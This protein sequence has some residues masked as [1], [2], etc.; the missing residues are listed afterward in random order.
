MSALAGLWRFDGKP[1]A[2]EG[3]ARMLA[4]QSIYGPHDGRQWS[5]GSLALGRRLYRTLPEDSFDLQP[6]HGANDRFVLVADVRLDNREELCAALGIA[7]PRARQLCDADVLLA[8]LERWSE[9]ALERLTGDF[10]FALW[11]SRERSLLL[12]RDFVGQRPLFYHRGRDFFAFASTTRGLHGL[13]DVPRKPDEQAVAEFVA[14]IPHHGPRSFYE[15]IARVE[16]GHFVSVTREGIKSQ[17]YWNPP[18]PDPA[19]R[20]AGDHVEGLRHHLDEATKARLRG[21]GGTVA[22]HLSAGLDSAAVTATAARSLAASGGKVVAFTAVPR[23]GYEGSC[24]PGRIADEGPLAAATAALYPN[25]EHVLIRS[26][27]VS[28]VAELDRYFH[29]F[30]QPMIN[31]VNLAWLSSINAAARDRKLSIL[32]TG[33]MGNLSLSYAGKEFLPELLARGRPLDWLRES[34]HLVAAGRMRWRGA[35][36]TS[37]GPFLPRWLWQRLPRDAPGL[38]DYSALRPD[39]RRDFGLDRIAAERGMDPSLRP[40]RSAFDTRLHALAGADP[41]NY[42]K[43]WL[44]GWGIDPR[45]PTADRRLVEFCLLAP[46]KA[47]VAGGETRLMARRALGD[48]LPRTVIEAQTRGF[49]AADWHVGLSTA[50]EQVAADLDNLRRCEPVARIIDLDRLRALIDHWPEG[51]WHHGR[52]MR[53]YRSALLRGIASG[54]FLRKASGSNA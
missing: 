26:A 41:G 19:A 7:P 11:D 4:A 30:D 32:L 44:A 13:P 52:I 6:V 31:P 20:L 53:S 25:V 29:L 39:C 35:L 43:G 42:Q 49:Q 36:A 23:E 48:R 16:P 1:D 37:F 50:R 27:E 24:P 22:T 14:L 28:P 3:C 21:A 47:F 12:A 54:H 2:A 34:S 46:M 9:S 5:A 38:W 40:G 51:G 45:D 10:A 8:S 18:R 15:G 33:Q 17:R